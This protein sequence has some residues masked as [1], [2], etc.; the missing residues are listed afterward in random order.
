MVTNEF[1]VSATDYKQLKTLMTKSVIAF[2]ENINSRFEDALSVLNAFDIFNPVSI[3]ER[4]DKEFKDYGFTSLLSLMESFY[5]S[6]EQDEKIL[7]WN[8]NWM[9]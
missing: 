8:S 3:P 1:N 6:I 4:T 7:K 2:Q 9:E 5:P